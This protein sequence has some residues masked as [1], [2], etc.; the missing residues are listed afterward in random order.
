MLNTEQEFQGSSSEN[1][2][3]KK[4]WSCILWFHC[5]VN[6]NC[7]WGSGRHPVFNSSIAVASGTLQKLYAH[8]LREEKSN[9]S[10]TLSAETVGGDVLS[11]FAFVTLL[12]HLLYLCLPH[13]SSSY[14]EIKKM[15]QWS[16]TSLGGKK[17]KEEFIHTH[18]H[19]HAQTRTKH[20]NRICCVDL[21]SVCLLRYVR[22]SF[23][24]TVR[25]K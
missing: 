3:Q 1:T 11:M 21:V 24:A 10:C 6:V 18:I 8:K 2:E 16:E 14:S 25:W 9:N 19:T 13:V 7:H 12:Y 20:I 22:L 17:K 4:N 5:T 23:R 15:S